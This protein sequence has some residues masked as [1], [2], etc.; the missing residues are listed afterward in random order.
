MTT[1]I[2]RAAVGLVAGLALLPATAQAATVSKPAANDPLT[3]FTVDGTTVTVSS[4]NRKTLRH[5]AGRDVAALCEA[6]LDGFL[7]QSEGTPPLP[8]DFSV[9][10]NKATWAA[11]AASVTVTLPRDIS[12]RVDACYLNGLDDDGNPLVVGFTAAGRADIQAE[13]D[14]EADDAAAQVAAHQLNVAYHAARNGRAGG[15]YGSAREVARS[16]RARRPKLHVRVARTLPKVKRRGVVYVVA[17]FTG[18][19]DLMLAELDARG[20]LQVLRVVR[21]RVIGL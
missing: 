2:R 6:G 14:S 13:L 5:F 7:T 15:R 9:L 1:L 16:I 11:G 3:T 4:T 12:D 10:A 18:G 8:V 21:G 19:R 17:S 20:N